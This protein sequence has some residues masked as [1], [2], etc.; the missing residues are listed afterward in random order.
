[1]F[2]G[3]LQER[4]IKKLHRL[5]KRK[6]ARIAGMELKDDARQA[7]IDKVEAQFERALESYIHDHG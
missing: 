7:A 5:K 6:L 2:K 4:Q 1:M 3:W